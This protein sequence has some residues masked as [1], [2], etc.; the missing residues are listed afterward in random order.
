MRNLNLKDVNIEHAE[1][2]TV[3]DGKIESTGISMIVNCPEGVRL[4]LLLSFEDVCKMYDA[5]MDEVQREELFI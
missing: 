3:C 5:V 2:T 4:E 1:V